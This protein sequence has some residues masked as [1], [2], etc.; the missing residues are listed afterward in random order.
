MK[1]RTRGPRQGL[2]AQPE[3]YRVP[4]VN[5][6]I[7]DALLMTA[8]EDDDLELPKAKEEPSLTMPD[9]GGQSG[10]KSRSLPQAQRTRFMKP[11]DTPQTMPVLEPHDDLEIAT[12][13][14][15]PPETSVPVQKKPIT[16]SQQGQENVPDITRAPMPS[17]T[18]NARPRYGIMKLAQGGGLTFW[19]ISWLIALSWVSGI[20][21]FTL[22]VESGLGF[23][24]LTEFKL[25]IIALIAVLPVGL[26][27]M[28]ALALRMA[29]RLA[30]EANRAANMADAMVAPAAAASNEAANIVG[31]LRTEIDNCVASVHTARADLEALGQSLRDESARL[32]GSAQNAQ[33]TS[34]KL[35]SA[36][37]S[38]REALDRL[39]QRMDNQTRDLVES[40]G[41]QGRLISEAS[42]LAQLQINEAESKLIKGASDLAQTASDAH[43]QTSQLTQE[44]NLQ[45]ERF[46]SAGKNVAEQIRSVEEGLN[47]QRSELENSASALRI[48]QED[49]ASLI[50]K[51]HRQLGDAL[52]V[53]RHATMELGDTS[54]R[55]VDILRDIVVNAQQQFSTLMGSAERERHDFEARI[56]DTLGTISLVA[57]D[58]RDEMINETSRAL[59]SLTQNAQEAR[60]AADT[61]AQSAQTRLDRLNETLFDTNK[62]ADEAYETRLNAARKLIEDSAQMIE[63]AGELTALKLAARLKHSKDA[64]DE[65]TQ[66]F[67][68]ITQRAELLPELAKARLSD[69]RHEVEANLSAMTRAAQDAAA[70]TEAVDLAFQ[71]RIRRN[72]E[73]LSEAVRLM[74]V[75]ATAPA[76]PAAITLSASAPLAKP[77][78]ASDP[79]PEPIQAPAPEPRPEPMIDRAALA[80]HTIEPTDFTP[81]QDSPSLDD[82][83]FE[84]NALSDEEFEP[85]VSHQPEAPFPEPIIEPVAE[86]IPTAQSTPLSDPAILPPLR[87]ADNRPATTRRVSNAEGW[88]WRDLLN[89]M[90]SRPTADTPPTNPDQNESPPSPRFAIGAPLPEEGFDNLDDLM[91]AEI[92]SMGI[93]AAT[94]I[95]MTRLEE[96]ISMLATKGLTGAR[97]VIKRIAPAAVKR[98]AR[99]LSQDADNLGH[100][101]EFSG[102]YDR[103]VKI[104]LQATA[105]AEALLNILNTDAG[106]A[107]LLIEAALSELD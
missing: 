29:A 28:S 65:V 82:P 8:A 85:T 67:D 42:T 60:L 99:R 6:T 30:Q 51:L 46:E 106:R 32:L 83:S 22:S 90:E 55:G 56:N 45:T 72:Y 18:R 86:A 58:A 38:E 80:T 71:D 57:A 2:P 73:M 88:T 20:I 107:Y 66:A 16:E 87:P 101:R 96:S 5:N 33:T 19:G 47:L 93:D 35:V 36:L 10:A 9:Q 39:G 7:S 41:A 59:A 12:I 76:A 11:K 14:T 37:G 49:F 15:P 89:G 27:L 102:F 13:M 69:I 25:A 84:M 4:E 21:A 31:L 77:H 97:P 50:T 70:Q 95:T 61:A 1:P 68:E 100:A 26:I 52:S 24:N 78:I 53:T 75:V 3:P 43:V 103:Q 105:K 63:Q 92:A 62:R 91:S 98:L 81:P 79:K 40:I 74:G 54:T 34:N 48:E 94:L 104:A 64:L 44:L 23:A 17:A